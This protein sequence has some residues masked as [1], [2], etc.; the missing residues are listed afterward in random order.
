MALPLI[1]LFVLVF[2]SSNALACRCSFERNADTIVK[3]RVIQVYERPED[4]E[5]PVHGKGDYMAMLL[6]EETLKGQLKGHVPVWLDSHD[7][8]TC[9]A[10]LET[11]QRLIIGLDRGRENYFSTTSCG[12][13]EVISR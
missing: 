3:A 8:N 2:T 7:A 10:I 12:I 4:R 13:Y 1:A 11:G 5:R 9:G 6:V